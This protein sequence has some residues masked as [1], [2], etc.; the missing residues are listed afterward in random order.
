MFGP[1]DLLFDV[2]G[3]QTAIGAD[4]AELNSVDDET[5]EVDETPE[6]EEPID[7]PDE[8]PDEED[9]KPAE[10]DEEEEEE[11]ESEPEPGPETT[12]PF[13]R[14]SIKQLTEAYPDLFKKFP[15]LKDMY[16]RE[17]EFSKVYPTIDDAK[18][19][20]ENNMAF[21]SIRTDIFSGDGTKFFNAVKE[22]SDKGLERFAAKVLPSLMK[23]SPDAFW[24]AA[25]PLV[26]DVA[27]NMFNKGVKENN[28][29]MQ[30]AARYLSQFFF[31]EVEFAEGKKTS[32][33]KEEPSEVSKER[34]AFETER[35]KEF[36]SSVESDIKTQLV[37]L[38][39]GK[40]PKTGKIRLDPEDVLSPFIRMTI[41]DRV[42]ADLGRQLQADKDHLRFM[43][44]LFDRAKKNGRKDADK[45]S[46]ISAY[47]ARARA[48]VPSLR[49]KYLSEA[50]G[51]RASGERRN[52][53]KVSSIQEHRPSPGKG[54][55]SARQGYNPKSIDY[56]KTSDA[57]ILNDTISYK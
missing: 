18:E 39:T 32:V 24:R 2:E 41:I 52:K 38:I 31:G 45:A 43:D 9:E 46:I 44:S 13:D 8:E 11:P 37:T 57:D 6:D 34:E 55:R 17:S 23:V 4:L 5:P 10:A 35:S 51:K 56:S 14:P 3:S 25:N 19:A 47:L 16:F 29:N 54:S 48:I 26:E 49:S 7:E 1:K 15:S 20:R 27:R 22:V 50:L 28:E 40:D 30:N 36:M 12:H 42:V 21:N 53:E 33:I